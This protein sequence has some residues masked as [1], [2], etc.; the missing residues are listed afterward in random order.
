MNAR[1]PGFMPVS[2][3]DEAAMLVVFASRIYRRGEQCLC[4]L[5]HA[6]G[7]C[8]AQAAFIELQETIC[9]DPRSGFTAGERGAETINRHEALLLGALA[10]WQRHP[11]DLSGHAF[12]LLLPPTVCRVAAP[13]AREFARQLLRAG[14]T[15]RMELPEIEAQPRWESSPLTSMH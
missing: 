11:G 15:L 12:E 4:S 14:Y 10:H 2:L 3:L 9:A 7:L 8:D 1:T 6:A 5:F 13:L